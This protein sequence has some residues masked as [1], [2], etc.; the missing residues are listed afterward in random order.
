[1]AAAIDLLPTLAD[2]AGVKRVGNQPLDGR[3]LKPLLDGS[4]GVEWPDRTIF[5]HWN[6]KISVR[7][8]THCLD[9]K[10]R[11]YDLAAD[12]G[13]ESDIAESEPEI[14]A[15]LTP[16]VE[17]WRAE[18]MPLL[19][20]DDRPLPVGYREFPMTQLPARDGRPH[21]KIKRSAGAPNCSYFTNWT[22]PSDAMTWDLE[23]AT[24]GRY[25]VDISY[26][27]PEADLGAEIELSFRDSR[28]MGTLNQAN[29]PP[30]LGGEYDRVPRQ[31]ESYVKDFKPWRIGEMELEKGRGELTLRASQIPGSQAMEIRLITL[32]L[33][34]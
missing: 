26:A 24:A 34:P 8:Q 4:S 31:G 21:G 22:Q 23:V 7:T 2:L 17:E 32:T 12:P 25:A 10:G 28:L 19:R 3:S 6:R 29:D 14:A 27:C 15:K 33:L 18:M 13:Q 9:E 1:M 20:E 5:S 30:L 11:L 16:A